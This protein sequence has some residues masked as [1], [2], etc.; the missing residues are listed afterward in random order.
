VFIPI[1]LFT[2]INLSVVRPMLL[3]GHLSPHNR[4][5][6]RICRTSSLLHFGSGCVDLHRST[7]ILT[8][9]KAASRGDRVVQYPAAVPEFPSTTHQIS[10]F[11][12]R[13]PKYKY[14]QY[15][16]SFSFFFI[17]TTTRNY[18]LQNQPFYLYDTQIIHFIGKPPC[19]YDSS[20]YRY[21]GHL[22]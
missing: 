3:L 8:F 20:H 2:P 11:L 22:L 17:H 14:P 13:I 12:T 15:Q 19:Q 16:P 1:G 18:Q 7:S 9:S 5:H 4:C 10:Q 21:L 6:C